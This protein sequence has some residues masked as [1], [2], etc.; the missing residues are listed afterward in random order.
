MS[1]YI[2]KNMVTPNSKPSPAL[3]SIRAIGRMFTRMRHRWLQRQM[4]IALHELDDRLLADIGIHRYDIPRIV[5]GLSP[6]ELQ[7][8][9]VARAQPAADPEDQ[10][11]LRVA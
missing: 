3:K 5:A 4:T 1:V 10:P 9:P 8:R 6:K 11:L 7:M 2:T